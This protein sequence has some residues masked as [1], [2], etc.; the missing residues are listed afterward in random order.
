MV[1]W[2]HR[3]TATKIRSFVGL[4]GYYRRLIK[5]FSRIVITLTQLAQKD[6]LFVWT[7]ICE[8]SFQEL[9]RWLTTSPILVLPDINDSF[10]VYC[11][12]SHHRLGCVLM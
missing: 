2:E 11:N 4:A 7:D 6:Q 1:Q 9:K 10:D 8:Q 5:G 3:R 12:V